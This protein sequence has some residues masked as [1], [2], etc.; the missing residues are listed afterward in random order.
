MSSPI[1]CTPMRSLRNASSSKL[2][3]SGATN[4]SGP[5]LKKEAVPKDPWNNDFK[6][7]SPG[8][9]GGYDLVS[10]GA[11]GREGGDGVN[12]DITSWQ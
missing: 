1:T 12:K 10:Y 3:P 2:Q 4:W 7:T 5:Y 6:Y 9:H 8:Q 11:D